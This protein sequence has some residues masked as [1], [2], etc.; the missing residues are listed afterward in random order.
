MLRDKW[1]T[2]YSLL[3]ILIFAS[4][5]ILLSPLQI[6]GWHPI[7]FICIWQNIFFYCSA[8][9]FSVLLVFC[10]SANRRSATMNSLNELPCVIVR[11]REPEPA[12]IKHICSFLLLLFRSCDSGCSATTISHRYAII[13]T[14]KFNNKKINKINLSSEFIPWRV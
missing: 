8:Q 11:V 5:A 12:T 3:F 13:L 4:R 2:I 6:S 10:E 7:L 14:H 9:C 1:M